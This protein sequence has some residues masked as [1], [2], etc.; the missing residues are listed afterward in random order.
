[1]AQVGLH[2]VDLADPAGWLQVEGKVGP[3]HRDADAVAALGEGTH[4][5]AAQE[6]R[7]AE[8]GDERF[9]RGGGHAAVFR[10]RLNACRIQDRFSPVQGWQRTNGW[11]NLRANSS[12]L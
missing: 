8:D 7:A 5:M 9:G 3:A 6:A 10:C 12:E 4:H 11:A 2:R 1:M